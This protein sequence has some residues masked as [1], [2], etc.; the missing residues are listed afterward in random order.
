MVKRERRLSIEEAREIP[1]FEDWLMSRAGRNYRGE[2]PST[3]SRISWNITGPMLWAVLKGTAAAAPR[4]PNKKR[5][6]TASEEEVIAQRIRQLMRLDP[7]R[8]KVVL[9]VVLHVLALA[10]SGKDSIVV[11]PSLPPSLARTKPGR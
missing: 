9:D 11:P 6:G 2:T 4:L 8:A 10:E 3:R 7:A 1:G 5:A